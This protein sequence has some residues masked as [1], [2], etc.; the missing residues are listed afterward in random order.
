[1]KTNVVNP[2]IFTLISRATCVDFDGSKRCVS[3]EDLRAAATNSSPLA[4]AVPPWATEPV[5]E[6]GK[7]HRRIEGLIAP[8]TFNVDPSAP[9]ETILSNLIGAGRWST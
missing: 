5:G 7:D 1:M 3:V 6:L 2:G 4:L 9:P 8:G